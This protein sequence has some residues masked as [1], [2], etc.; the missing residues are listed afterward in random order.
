MQ[1]KSTKHIK[2]METL[3]ASRLLTR[4][5]PFDH[6]ILLVRIKPRAE[7]GNQETWVHP[8][9]N[10]KKKKQAPGTIRILFY[11]LWTNMDRWLVKPQ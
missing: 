11:P 8:A 1:Q 7:K 3:K 4:H 2:N 5:I 6:F 9:Q 10:L